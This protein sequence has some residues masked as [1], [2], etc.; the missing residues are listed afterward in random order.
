[1]N[2]IS[3]THFDDILRRDDVLLLPSGAS[4]FVSRHKFGH[5]TEAAS[6]AGS[7]KTSAIQ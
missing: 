7:R 2:V 3:I 5:N 1:M 6:L 4:H